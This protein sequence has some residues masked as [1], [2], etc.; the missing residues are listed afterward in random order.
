MNVLN[1]EQTLSAWIGATLPYIKRSTFV[2]SHSSRPGVLLNRPPV[3]CE[4]FNDVDNLVSDWWRAQRD[5]TDLPGHDVHAEPGVDALK[6]RLW[7]VQLEKR[8]PASLLERLTTIPTVLLFVDARRPD[9]DL[10]DAEPL[11][12]QFLGKIAVLGILNPW[13]S[14]PW[15]ATVA[16]G[17]ISSDGLVLW[18][19]YDPN[20]L[21][22]GQSRLLL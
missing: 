17:W 14:L 13:P 8:R 5:R 15:E 10:D 21:E 7:N 2:E 6:K 22:H 3:Q 4:I 12:R 9:V 16:P 11:V 18:T 20:E 19:N 1:S